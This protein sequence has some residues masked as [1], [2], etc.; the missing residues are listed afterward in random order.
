MELLTSWLH[1]I[2]LIVLFAIVMDLILPSS[3]MQKYIKL[4]MGLLIMMTLLKPIAILFDKQFDISRIEWPQ[5]VAQFASL[6]TIKREAADMQRE[7]V[8]QA[9]QYWSAQLEK[10]IKQQV[11]SRFPM[12]VMHVKAQFKSHDRQTAE[13]PEIQKLSLTVR[14]D[15]EKRNPNSGIYPVQPIE[16]G[17]DERQ[18]ANS[19]PADT[20]QDDQ[21]L[22]QVKQDL[23]DKLQIAASRITIDWNS[24]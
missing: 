13:A 9:E 8:N 10:V 6:D 14:R 22:E 15:A 7:Q 12:E 1:Q 17:G 24:I 21:I 18:S 4:V 5:Q 2:V 20:Q 23:A 19:W 11:E 16:I 3:S